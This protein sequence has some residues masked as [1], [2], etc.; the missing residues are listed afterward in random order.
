MAGVRVL[1]S[2]RR[3]PSS[4][5]GR[6]QEAE[7]ADGSFG[8]WATQGFVGIASWDVTSSVLIPAFMGD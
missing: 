4:E 5:F 3:C 1:Q 6:F 8:P 7:S 2:S